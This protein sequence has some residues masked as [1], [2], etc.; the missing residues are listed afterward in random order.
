M[1]NKILILIL[2]V[3]VLSPP[4]KAEVE[5]AN[6]FSDFT[7]SDVTITSSEDIN[8]KLVFESSTEKGIIESQAMPLKIDA[9]QTISKTIIWDIR[10]QADKFDVKVSIYNGNI[11]I[12]EKSTQVTYG[13][14]ALPSYRVVDFAASNKGAQMLLEAINPS[15]VDMRIE[16]IDNGNIIFTTTK[17][18]VALSKDETNGIKI[19]WPFPLNDDHKYTVRG[20][21]TLRVVYG[22]PLVNSYISNF[23]AYN[24]VQIIPGE[25]KVDEY[26]ASV[27]LRGESQVPFDGFI[28]ITVRN[29][30][31]NEIQIYTQQVDKIIL[32]GREDTTGVVWNGLRPGKYDVEIRAMTTDN[33]SLSEYRTVLRMPEPQK[34]D[35][36]SISTENTGTNRLPGFEAL[37]LIV[38]FGIVAIIKHRKNGGG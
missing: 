28:D 24:D 22:S 37:Y 8:G 3:L 25:V 17:S 6:I 36:Q 4:T 10:P 32:S 12:V 2:V 30:A 18:D 35:N 5:I 9:G 1:E 31:T 21:I 34:E 13:S 20:K 15:A 33:V 19:D 29:L 11:I 7:S 38:A 23:V 14:M 26:G 27:T 16:L